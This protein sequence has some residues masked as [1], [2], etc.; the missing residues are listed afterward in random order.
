MAIRGRLSTAH[1]PRVANVRANGSLRATGAPGESV[2]AAAR[3][4]LCV[5]S[6]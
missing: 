3:L 1:G 2:R 4:P 5:V 6:A